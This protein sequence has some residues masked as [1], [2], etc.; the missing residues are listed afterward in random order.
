MWAHRWPISIA[1]AVI[2]SVLG[3]V[4]F[5]LSIITTFQS[6][7]SAILGLEL[8]D[9]WIYI[10]P[11][12]PIL[13]VFFYVLGGIAIFLIGKEYI[14]TERYVYFALVAYL[15]YFPLAGVEWTIFSTFTAFPPLFLLG[16]YF[17][18]IDFRILSGVMLILSGL[19][20]L[21]FTLVV[22]FTAA[23]MLLKDRNRMIP[24]RENHFAVSVLIISLLFFLI[25]GTL[26]YFVGYYGVINQ[27]GY[28]FLLALV[29]TITFAKPLFFVV[30]LVPI[31]TF[32]FFGPR[33]LPVTIPYYIF[34]IIVAAA[35]NTPEPLI[36]ILDLS[37]PLALIGTIAWIGRKSEVEALPAETRI[38]RFALFTLVI[39]NILVFV[40]Y[41][42]FLGVLSKLFGF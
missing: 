20:F 9:L 7:F 10:T 35:G 39:M 38:I 23:G 13:N 30:L 32:G 36:A 18:K 16:F 31:I 29:S 19:T 14:I 25:G 12:M 26:G 3:L 2:L 42:P 15:L 24:A 22:A 6:L 40:S 11:V 34:G 1:A 8:P 28:G 5:D 27:S 37:L 41:I 17:Y 33:L 21:L 4:Y